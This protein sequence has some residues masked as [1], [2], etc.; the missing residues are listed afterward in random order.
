MCPQ[1][2]ITRGVLFRSA[3]FFVLKPLTLSITYYVHLLQCLVLVSKGPALW[4]DINVDTLWPWHWD[5]KWLWHWKCWFKGLALLW[6]NFHG[7]THTVGLTLKCRFRVCVLCIWCYCRH[8]H[9]SPTDLCS[10]YHW[11]R[12][13]TVTQSA[14]FLHHTT[15]RMSGDACTSHRTI[16]VSL[17]GYV[18]QR[19]IWEGK[20]RIVKNC[21]NWKFLNLV[22]VY[23]GCKYFNR[24]E[25]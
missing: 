7:K 10:V 20:L 6:F 22:T 23:H 21:K 14:P 2:R 8:F 16:C 15:N 12:S 24:Y 13:W 9:W 1:K 19:E 5:P 11:R 18:C 25:Y 3:C 17:V 4:N